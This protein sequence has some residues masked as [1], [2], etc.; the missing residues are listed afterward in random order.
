MIIMA[1]LTKAERREKI[2]QAKQ[3]YIKGF[4]APTISEIMG[5]VTIRTVEKWIKENDF[6][7]AK[8]SVIISLSEIRNSILESYADVLDGKQPKIKPDA[9]V[10]YAAAFEKFSEKSKLL[11]YQHEA[12]SALCDEITLDI[13]KTKNKKTKD[14]M[15]ESLKY[16]RNIMQRVLE[17]NTREVIGNE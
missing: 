2:E 5:D 7:R 6:E 8:R 1:K 16:I 10:K 17:K 4:D 14:T 3:M 11:T 15:L 9:A 13:Q 12:Y